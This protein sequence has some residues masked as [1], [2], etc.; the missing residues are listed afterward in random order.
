MST[1]SPEGDGFAAHP[2]DRHAAP[3]VNPM[4]GCWMMRYST[5]RI[6]ARGLI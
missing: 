4:S 1:A 5:L 2:H 6:T 3:Y